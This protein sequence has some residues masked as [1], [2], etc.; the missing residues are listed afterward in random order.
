MKAHEACSG[1]APP[2]EWGAWLTRV[3]VNACRDRRRA[4]WWMRFRRWSDRVDDMALAAQDP[5]PAEAAIGA[6]IRRRIWL[7]FR[8]LPRRQ[9]EVFVLRHIE[10]ASTE[11][12]AEV[13]G[14][15]PG[16][17]KRHLFRAIRRLR[18]ALGDVR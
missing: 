10:E 12:V 4:G 3:A 18:Q 15:N 1:S 5:G 6:E 14:L 8:E 2:R 16:S 13:L 11:E 17:V 7:A 9:R